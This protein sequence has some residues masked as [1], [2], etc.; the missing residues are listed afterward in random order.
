M[1]SRDGSPFGKL[2]LYLQ[3]VTGRFGLRTE[4]VVRDSE[5]RYGNIE[6]A[7]KSG[8]ISKEL[9]MEWMRR[10]LNVALAERLRSMDAD[11]KIGGESSIYDPEGDVPADGDEIGEE[12][13]DLIQ[14]QSNC[15]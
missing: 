6:V 8:K 13:D 2:L 9:T 7:S 5:G 14:Q 15:T 1:I 4:P 11:A 12:A 3:E 10:V